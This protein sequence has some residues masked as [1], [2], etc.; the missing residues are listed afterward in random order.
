M[1]IEL[2]RRHNSVRRQTRIH[3]KLRVGRASTIRDNRD[4]VSKHNERGT[5]VDFPKGLGG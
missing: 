4:K 3:I 1:Q 5:T 2:I